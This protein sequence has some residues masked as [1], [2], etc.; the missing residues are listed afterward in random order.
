M[1]RWVVLACASMIVLTS[2]VYAD[3][4]TGPGGYAP[5]RWTGFYA[6]ADIG[7]HWSQDVI[8]GSTV[9]GPGAF[10]GDADLAALTA[11]LPLSLNSQGF[12]VGG[13]VGYNWQIST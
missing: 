9:N 11:N 3:G 8:T 4:P 10:F 13:H 5:V 7:G 12:A 2:S 1:L 6:G